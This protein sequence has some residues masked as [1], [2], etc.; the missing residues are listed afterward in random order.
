VS[1]ALPTFVIVGAQKCGTTALH[2][3]LARH[4]E[5][6][7]SR[8]KELDFFIEERNWAKGLDW[9]RSRFDPGA[10]ARGESSPNYTAH[11][12]FAGVPERMA[13][14]IPEAKLIF[15]VRDPIDRIRANWLHTYSNRVEHRSMREAVLDPATD[16]VTRS[17]YHL[18]L[19]RFLGHY[20]FERLMVIEQDELLS[21]RRETL[22]RV[23][24]FLGV[25]EDIW[26]DAF[27]EPRLETATRRRRTPLGAL[28]ANRVRV[29]TW[30]R[31][32]DRWPFS[33]P[34]EHVEMDGGLRAELTAL[35]GDDIARFRELTGRDFASWSV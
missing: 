33:R 11:P 17:R 30:R 12:T 34:F 18:Q 2:S 21:D 22:R 35:L 8:P 20:P 13:E 9:Y 6:S 4:P 7:M 32:R 29:R 24:G 15:M 19:S 1:G 5:I 27:S 23:F 31:I 26:R 3:Y 14:L 28:V 10:R 25:R 16:Y